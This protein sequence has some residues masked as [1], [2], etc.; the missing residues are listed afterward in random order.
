MEADVSLTEAGVEF[1]Q[2]KEKE[3]MKMEA[4]RKAKEKVMNKKDKM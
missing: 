4:K 3:K 1:H 2:M